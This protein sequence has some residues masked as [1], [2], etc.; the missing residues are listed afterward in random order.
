MKK[1]LIVLAMLA[2]FTAPAFAGAFDGCR[3]IKT[4][5]ADVKHPTTYQCLYVS[6]N[7]H[8]E[9]PVKKLPK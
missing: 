7:N 9:R 1:T 2:A 6:D 3:V 5:P 4:D 8:G